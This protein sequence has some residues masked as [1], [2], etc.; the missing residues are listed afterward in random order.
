MYRYIY[1]HKLT[2]RLVRPTLNAIML[3]IVLI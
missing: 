2:Y 3:P 1:D